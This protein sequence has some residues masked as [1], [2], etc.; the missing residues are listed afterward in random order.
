[1]A[2]I[3]SGI[4]EVMLKLRSKYFLEG[5]ALMGGRS[6]QTMRYRCIYYGEDN[7]MAIANNMHTSHAHVGCLPLLESTSSKCGVGP[8][9]RRPIRVKRC[10]EGKVVRRTIGRAF[11]KQDRL[12]TPHCERR[13]SLRA[14]CGPSI[15]LVLARMVRYLEDSR[16]HTRHHG[17]RKVR[18]FS[19]EIPQKVN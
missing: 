10:M 17:Q 4:S 1:M 15:D 2:F 12:H 6:S 7:C 16:A 18:A 5:R 14:T 8:N 11:V 3:F 9:G 13:A 19:A